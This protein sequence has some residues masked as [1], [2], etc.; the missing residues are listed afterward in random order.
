MTFRCLA[1]SS[2]S[3]AIALSA[4][5]MPAAVGFRQLTSCYPVAVQRGTKATINVRSNFTLD[6]TYAAFSHPAGLVMTYAETKPIE[7]P[8]TARGTPG[9]PFKFEVQV[10]EDQPLG[11]HEFRLATNQ[12]VSSVSHLLVTEFPVIEEK[13]QENGQASTAQEIKLPVAVCGV[14]DKA[15][16]VDCFRFP[17]QAGQ[18]LTFQVYAQRMTAAIHD[19]VSRS[20]YSMDAI[21]VL[22][23]PNGQVVAQNDNFYGGDSVL[24]CKLPHDGVYVLEIRDTRYGGDPRWSYCVE[25]S[26]RPFVQGV[27]PLAVERGKSQSAE[28]LGFALGNDAG[29]ILS[30]DANEPA[31]RKSIAFETP[32]GR[33]N[34]IEVVVSD[35]PQMIARENHSPATAL[36]LAFPLGVSARFT[37]SDE[38]H[39]YAIQAKKGDVYSFEVEAQR[40]GLP[41]DSVLEVFDDKGK[42]LSEA[43]DAPLMRDTQLTFQAPADGKFLLTVRDLHGRGGESFIYYLR[44]ERTG[45]DFELL[46]EWYYAML[47]P[48]TNTLWFAKL[49]RLNG[50]TGP[51]KIEVEGLPA[52][53]SFT[54]VTIPAGMN[55]CGVILSAAPEAKTGATLVKVRGT[56]EIP[57]SDGQPR[58]VVREGRAVCELQNQGGGQGRWPVQTQIVGVVEKLDLLKVEAAPNEITLLPGNKA[59]LKVRIERRDGFTDP[60]SLGMAFTYFTASLGEQLPPGVTLGAAS[61]TRLSGKAL[62]AKLILEASPKAISVDRLPVAVMA[63]VSISFSISTT[64]ASNPIY[65]TIPAAVTSAK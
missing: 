62:E 19:M 43:D 54:P 11:V 9:K 28:L 26:E 16:D 31:G 48:G 29:M 59:E 4:V 52:G 61:Q 46:G 32:R 42:K 25:A 53:V 65:L 3:I 10:P 38:V 58:Q 6:G 30:A 37:K 20:G 35:Y 50:F 23:G 27:Y 33:T 18:E 36:E 41:L 64:Y 51:V 24:N 55:H 47:A 13:S 39:Y 15:E 2:L 34:P 60:V 12:A 14:I 49:N 17:G 8:L 7:A 21:V 56:A 57:G 45:P 1:V 63:G 44:T 5:H 40:R 22:F